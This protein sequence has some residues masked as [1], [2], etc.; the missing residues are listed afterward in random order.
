[1]D[2]A[3]VRIEISYKTV[4]F[5]VA[6]ILGAWFLVRIREIII[7]VFLSLILVSALLRPVEWLTARKIP[8]ALSV[9][10][11]YLL[12]LALI[13]L[14]IGIVFPPLISQTADF[15]S[16]LP[17][18]LSSINDLLIF[19]SIPIEN[20]SAVISNQAQTAIGDIVA[21]S[22][23]I[24]SSIFSVI[25]MLVLTL[26]LLLEWKILV[27]VI[28]S[29]FSGK[30]E[31]RV[32]NLIS[33][34]EKGLGFWVRGQ[35]ALSLIIGVVTYIGLTIMGI[36]F[37]LPLALIAG[38]LEIIPFAGP[39]I[40]AVPAVLVGL[41]ISP[42]M[43]LAVVALYTI[44]QQLENHL[45]VPMVMSRV[46]GLQPAAV[47]IALLIGAKLSG[48]GGALLAIPLIVTAKIIIK[49][50]LFEDQKLEEDLQES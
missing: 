29:P 42:L 20:I 28:A 43:A 13:G 46:V 34:I 10:I 40:A 50:L 17:V 3:P 24:F 2:K 45:I 38:I 12:L 37:A 32:V 9:V 25:T 39:I 18:I 41:T 30:Q 47:I 22:T 27:R 35:L 14:A 15:L 7:L 44:V 26:Y 1:M 36:P 21:I 19:Y 33:R 6:I 49:D 48:I 8:R 5:I 4:V 31:K 23:A 16:K 11:I